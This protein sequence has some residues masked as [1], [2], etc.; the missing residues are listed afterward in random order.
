MACQRPSLTTPVIRLTAQPSPR[1][2]R[3]GAATTAAAFAALLLIMLM[4]ATP[5]RA[6]S[7]VHLAPSV[8]GTNLT[9]DVSGPSGA[10]CDL[11]LGAGRRAADLP[12]VDLGRA[13]TGTTRWGVAS[14]TPT[15]RRPLYAVCESDGARY[16]AAAKVVIP[17]DAVEQKA[18]IS[19]TVL[20]VLLDVLLG[21]SLLLFVG[22]LVQMVRL[23]PRR[24]ETLLLT[25]ALVAGAVVALGA[26]A[27]GATFSDY[28]VEALTGS[29]P[30]GGAFKAVAVVVPGGV[31]AALGWYFIRV[32]RRSTAKGMRLIAFLGMLTIVGFAAIFAK[33]TNTQGVILG[34]AAIPNASFIAGII[35]AIL[36]FA[37]DPDEPADRSGGRLMGGLGDLLKRRPRGR[38]ASTGGAA[39]FAPTEGPPGGA[40]S[41]SNPFADD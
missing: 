41:R 14:G 32:M 2:R 6:A 29:R 31:S 1:P 34:A 5:G 24:S 27:A 21:G 11:Q 26:Q 17:P 13:G 9:V 33:A 15:G 8:A 3:W 36:V 7:D 22:A 12:S 18:S 19:A 38:R 4:T 20:N 25:M 30:A 40:G 23:E 39:A 37:P 16:K 28:T 10:T 35:L